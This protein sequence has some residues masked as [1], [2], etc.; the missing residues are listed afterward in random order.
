H[1]F[2]CGHGCSVDDLP[3]TE[4][5]LRNFTRADKVYI[6]PAAIRICGKESMGWRPWCSNGLNR[7]R[8]P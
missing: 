8:S 5:M 2:R 4:I 1:L 6:S 7:T 3:G